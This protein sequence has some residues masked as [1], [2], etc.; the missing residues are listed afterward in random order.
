MHVGAGLMTDFLD[1]KMDYLI[2]CFISLAL[3][4]NRHCLEAALQKSTILK[5]SDW[6]V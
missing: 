5:G 4:T 3:L 1:G 6:H 2:H